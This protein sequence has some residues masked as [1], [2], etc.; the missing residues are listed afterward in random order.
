MYCTGAKKNH[1]LMFTWQLLEIS[2]PG[3]VDM[4]SNKGLIKQTGRTQAQT[5]IV[6]Y[7]W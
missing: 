2:V 6:W 5:N 4:G 1:M 7:P 3:A